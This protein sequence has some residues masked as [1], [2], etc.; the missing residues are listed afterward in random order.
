MPKSQELKNKIHDLIIIGAGPAGLS[1][2]IYAKRYNM[3]FLIFG[4]IPGGTATEAHLVE[5]YPGYKS[6]SG[7]ELMQKFQEH[8]DKKIIQ[9]NINKIIKNKNKNFNIYSNQNIYQA[10]AII[11]ALGVKERKLEVKHEEKFLGK[12]ISYCVVCDG[13]FFKDK[14]VAVVGGGNA[15]LTGALKMADIAK[16]VYLIHRRDEFRGEPAWQDKVRENKKIELVLSAEVAEVHGNQV[17]EKIIL[18]NNR[19]LEI[20]G[21]FIEIGTTP[22]NCL[23]QE[24]G[25]KLN[26]IGQIKTNKSQETNISG[27]FAAGDITDFV[28]NQIVTAASQGAVAATSAYQFLQS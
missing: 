19:E 12:G 22:S 1:A 26:N 27:V 11:L 21:L 8:L 20:N 9:E 7:L 28:L 13:P 10:K 5:N 6:I 2:G 15:A 17:L 25:I 4:K 14:T 24:L 18:K 3:D 16:K 23:A